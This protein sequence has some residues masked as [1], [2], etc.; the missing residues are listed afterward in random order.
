MRVRALTQKHS[1][2]AES[3]S[4]TSLVM[5]RVVR[6]NR[7]VLPGPTIVATAA[8][9][10][11]S[12]PLVALLI[13]LQE[14]TAIGLLEL[15]RVSVSSIAAIIAVPVA[16][17]VRPLRIVVLASR[18]VILSGVQPILVTLIESYLTVVAV[19]AVAITVVATIIAVPITTIVLVAVTPIVRILIIRIILGAGRRNHADSD[20]ERQYHQDSPEFVSEKV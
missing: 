1:D 11:S 17:K 15:I 6:E 4:A 14:T 8:P 3:S 9:V 13:S 12:I 10:V 2:A 7:S 20:K 5:R 19:A 18:A 16:V